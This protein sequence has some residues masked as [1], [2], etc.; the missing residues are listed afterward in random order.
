MHHSCNVEPRNGSR[1][2]PPEDIL[3]QEHAVLWSITTFS[4]C[5]WPPNIGGRP[6]VT[7]STTAP[8]PG[9]PWLDAIFTSRRHQMQHRALDYRKGPRGM[10]REASPVPR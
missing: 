5:S 3:D 9:S 7:A 6:W 2:V 10:P 4:F 1:H 8:F